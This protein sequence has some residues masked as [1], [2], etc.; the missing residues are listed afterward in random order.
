MEYLSHNCHIPFSFCSEVR[1]YVEEE[2]QEIL[3][4]KMYGVEGTLKQES[5]KKG[6]SNKGSV[7]S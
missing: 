2:V 5:L 4:K 1:A 3:L 7:S 6:K